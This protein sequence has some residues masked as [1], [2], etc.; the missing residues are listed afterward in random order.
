MLSFNRL[1]AN[2]GQETVICKFLNDNLKQIK[3]YVLKNSFLCAK[4]KHIVLSMCFFVCCQ[5][6]FL[7]D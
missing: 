3:K 1:K 5:F 7:V 6:R 4:I 2:I